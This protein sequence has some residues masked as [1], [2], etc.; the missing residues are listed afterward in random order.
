MD[1][2]DKAELHRLT[3]THDAGTHVSLFIPTHRYGTD[4]LG[5]P[6]RWKNLLTQVE[7]EL[8][9]HGQDAGEVAELL[10]PA[11]AL[12]SDEFAWQHMSDGLVFF[13]RPGWHHSYRVAVDVPEV[14][15]IGDRFVTSP[16]L[17]VVTED[18][19]FLILAV[20][21]RRVRLLEAGEGPLR[22]VELDNVPTNLRDVVEPAEPRSDTMTV[23]TSSGRGAGRAVFY[24]HGA[25]DDHFKKDEVERFLRRVADGLHEYLH[26]QHAPMVLVGLQQIVSAYRGVSSYAAVLD[27]EVRSNPDELTDEQLYTSARELIDRIQVKGREADAERF[28]ALHGTGRASNDPTEI[29]QAAG[30]G[31]IDT[32][33]LATDECWGRTTAESP[34]V[35]LGADERFAHCE[36]LDHAGKDTL[37]NGGKVH[38][39]AVDEIPGDGDSAAIFRY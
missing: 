9:Q 14:A 11:V 30:E 38:L 29:G 33:F 20:S 16:L 39:A 5:D 1:V 24:G 34:V 21:Q 27:D 19:R 26:D 25:G 37:A 22:E 28:N 23:A 17:R 6:I 12:Q 4:T 15:I 8:T 13:L 2:I 35:R 18:C 31:R 36:A 10:K 32:L 7:T 3:E